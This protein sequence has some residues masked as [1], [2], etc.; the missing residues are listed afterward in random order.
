MQ[1]NMEK[2]K[3]S[4]YVFSSPCRV[5]VGDSVIKKNDL[6]R[7]DSVYRIGFRFASCIFTLKAIQTND[8]R[9]EIDNGVVTE[10]FC[11]ILQCFAIVCT[12]MISD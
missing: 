9:L 11:D 7:S 8:H 2:P 3:I 4:V 1:L 12:T 6:I 10:P 5:E